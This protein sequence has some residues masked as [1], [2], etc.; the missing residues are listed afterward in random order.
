MPNPE[1][2]ACTYPLPRQIYNHVSITFPEGKP[3]VFKNPLRV[4]SLASIVLSIKTSYQWACPEDIKALQSSAYEQAGRLVHRMIYEVVTK[5]DDW[6]VAHGRKR[7]EFHIEVPAAGAT[8]DPSVLSVELS[9][10]PLRTGKLFLPSVS[11]SPLPPLL[12]GS[13]E[14]DYSQYAHIPGM[15]SCEIMNVSAGVT[16]EVLEAVSQGS[17]DANEDGLGSVSFWIDRETGESGPLP[18]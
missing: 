16:V 8:A 17:G 14:P 10:A 11:V 7:G 18:I 4:G 5:N 1:S 3:T 2:P 9:I 12:P 15:P 13:S 6:I